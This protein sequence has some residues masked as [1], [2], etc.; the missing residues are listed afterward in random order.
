MRVLL[1]LLLS[2]FMLPAFSADNLLRWHDAQHFTVQ[3]STPLK[4]KRA[5]KLCALYP[6][7]KDSYWLSLNYGMQ[8]AARRYGVDLKVLEAGGYSQLAT[9]QAQIDQ[10]KQWG[11]E[12]ILLGSSTTSFPDLQKQVASLPV[13]EL[14]NAI[15]AP[16]VKS[17]VGV[18]WFQMGYQPGRYLV[19]WA[20]GKPL[21]VLLMPG[22]DN[23]GGSKEMVEGFRAAIAGSPVRIV[24]IALGDNDIEIQ[25]NLLQEMLERHPEIDVV[26]GT[27]IAAEAAMGEGR[28]LKTPLTV[29]SFYLSH[30]VYRG[31]KRGRVIMASSDQMVW[32]GELA[33]EQA[34]RQLQG[35][36]VSDNV[37]PPILVLTPKNADREHIRRSLSPGGF[38]P[39]YFYQHTSAAKK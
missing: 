19:Q 5:W 4:A 16:Q 18:P 35:Q 33:V 26:A 39:V 6:S 30:Q 22:P 3:A 27:A 21:N 2:L 34:I 29:V 15:D 8:E 17:R 36:S 31:L 1:F 13:I 7:L 10:C 25:R 32:Q 11:A 28:N 23:A 37:S 14:V 20:H 12:A 38:R 9:Q 24:D